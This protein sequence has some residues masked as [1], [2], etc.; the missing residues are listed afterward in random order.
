[1]SFMSFS[2]FLAN[3]IMRSDWGKQLM[4]STDR[5]FWFYANPQVVK[6]LKFL[7]LAF[8]SGLQALAIVCL[9]T[10]LR[11]AEGGVC[12]AFEDPVDAPLNA[13]S[14]IQPLSVSSLPGAIIQTFERT[15]QTFCDVW[16]LHNN[17]VTASDMKVE[18]GLCVLSAPLKRESGALSC[19]PFAA[20]YAW[21]QRRSKQC[22]DIIDPVNPTVRGPGHGIY[23]ST[24]VCSDAASAQFFSEFKSYATAVLTKLLIYSLALFALCSFTNKLYDHVLLLPPPQAVWYLEPLAYYFNVGMLLTCIIL[25]DCVGDLYPFVTQLSGTVH[26]TLAILARDCG[27]SMAVVVQNKEAANSAVFFFYAAA[28]LAFAMPPAL[29]LHALVARKH[30]RETTRLQEV[31]YQ[32][33]LADN[34]PPPP[35]SEPPETLGFNTESQVKRLQHVCMHVQHVHVL[36]MCLCSMCVCVYVYVR[37]LVRE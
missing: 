35:P 14:Q 30:Q 4:K 3:S 1:M 26:E 29:R 27:L 15:S 12:C 34:P 22:W 5:E 7:D 10:G 11:N 17:G 6:R 19:H 25:V 18:Q 13:T 36:C 28:V 8:Q 31:A 37:E 33:W 2:Q 23:D 20:Q 21:Q 9:I 24:K 32:E 16:T